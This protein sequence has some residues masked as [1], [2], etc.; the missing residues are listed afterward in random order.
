MVR[1]KIAD[2]YRDRIDALFTAEARDIANPGNR[3]IVG[4]FE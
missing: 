2:F 3:M 1:G 4:R